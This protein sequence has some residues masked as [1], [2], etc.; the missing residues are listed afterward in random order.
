MTQ[1]FVKNVTWQVPTLIRLRTQVYGDD[2]LY[3]ADPNLIYLDKTTRALWEQLGKDFTSTLPATAVATLRQ[4]YPLQQKVT[5]MMKQSGVKMLAGSD[6]G[7]I[8]VIPG[9]GLHQEFREL[10]ASGLSPLE[11]LQM[12]TLNG[13][14]F[15]KREASMGTVDAGKNADL[16]LLDANP[17]DDAANLSKISAVVLKGKYFSKSALEKLKSEVADA[18]A[19][20]PL[21]ALASAI[22]SSHID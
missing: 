18:Y 19:S 3:R 2:P 22:D 16:V 7:G 11:I 14:E 20:Q 13:A 4:F 15:M 9:F 12:T 21:K 1:A 8:W 6:L 10:A 5:K 17:I